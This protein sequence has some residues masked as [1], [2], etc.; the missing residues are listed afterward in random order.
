MPHDANGNEIKQGDLVMLRCEVLEV[1]EGEEVCNVKVQALDG[2][3]PPGIANW[4][5]VLTCNAN[6]LRKL[7]I[8]R[9][10]AM[11]RVDQFNKLK[12]EVREAAK[13]PGD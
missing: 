12:A 10:R 6:S 7:G 3:T 1:Y 13:A 11:E 2:E 9:Q 5:P 8:R 4:K